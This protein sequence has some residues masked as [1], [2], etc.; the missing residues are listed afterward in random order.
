MVICHCFLRELIFFERGAAVG[1]Y[2]PGSFSRLAAGRA[3]L[4]NRGSTVRTISE[5]LLDGLLARR[6]KVGRSWRCRSGCR[7]PLRNR[8]MILAYDQLN[9]QADQINDEDQKR[10]QHSV[11]SAPQPYGWA[12]QRFFLMIV[13]P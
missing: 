11:H 10:P 1:T 7:L 4:L 12:D 8:N 6:T 9:Q 13:H 3:N 2:F 5:I